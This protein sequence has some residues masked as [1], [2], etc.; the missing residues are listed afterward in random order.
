MALPLNTEGEAWMVRI[1]MGL[2]FK[3]KP[4]ILNYERKRCK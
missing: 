4:R 2:T 3:I 1:R